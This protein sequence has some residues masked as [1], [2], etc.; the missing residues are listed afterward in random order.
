M[1]LSVANLKVNT[2]TNKSRVK[3]PIKDV[4]ETIAQT[5]PLTGKHNV[6][7]IMV[8]DTNY[9]GLQSVY[10]ACKTKLVEMYPILKNVDKSANRYIQEANPKEQ[11]KWF[12]HMSKQLKTFFNNKGIYDLEIPESCVSIESI[13][14]SLKV[15]A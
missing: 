9:P 14:K 11:Q 12:E 6:L 15:A 10:D 5:K 7:G 2:L 1:A 8:G 3:V 4:L 13:A